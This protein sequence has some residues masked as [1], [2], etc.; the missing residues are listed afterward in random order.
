M[1]YLGNV[2]AEN[3]A[4]VS[5]QD[6]TGGSGTSF[7]LDY[8][9][10]SAGEIEVFVNNVRQE[11]TVAYTVNGTALTMTG[12]VAATD[13]FYVVFQGKAEK[14]GTIPEKQSDGTYVFPDDVTVN[15]D[16]TV[17]TNTLFVDSTN[18]RV[19]MGNVSP[20]KTLDVRGELAISNG[21]SSYWNINRDDSDG[22]LTFT[23]TDTSE[24]LR[25]LT[26]GGITFN[27]DTAAANALDDYEEG[28]FTPTL[29]FSSGTIGYAWNTGQ[30]TKVG[31]QVSANIAFY[32]NS[33]S[34]PYGTMGILGL[35]FVAA[36]GEQYVSA[37]NFG[38]IR[39]LTSD[40]KPVRGYI[41]SNSS[42]ITLTIN[43]TNGGFTALNANTLTTSTLIY[44]SIVYQTS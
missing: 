25:I 44:A 23:D 6:L 40:L 17:D 14:S 36:S 13:D 1:P 22:S 27:G 15:G 28:S 9:V 12:S 37:L 29:S 30:Y 19:G 24:R 26:G 41:N 8:P 7:T 11:P 20:Q 5:Y 34:S 33:I 21:T 16:L 2:P 32:V 31:N 10:G 42:L 3:Y 35:P 4:Q 43:A 39:S 38:I 18:N